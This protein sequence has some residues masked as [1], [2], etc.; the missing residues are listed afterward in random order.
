MVDLKETIFKAMIWEE[1]TKALEQLTQEILRAR[2]ERIAYE[3][4]KA[5][6]A[7]QEAIQTLD[8]SQVTLVTEQEYP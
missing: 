3:P 5:V 1:Q 8:I 6:E 4:V 7:P 2:E